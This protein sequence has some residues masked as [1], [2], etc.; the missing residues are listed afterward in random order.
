MALTVIGIRRF[1]FHWSLRIKL[2]I[3]RF[4]LARSFENL[5]RHDWLLWTLITRAGHAT[6]WRH[7]CICPLIDN[8][9]R[10]ITARVE[11]QLLYKKQIDSMLPWFCS[12]IDHRGRQNVVKTTVTHLPA[13]RVPLLC[14]YAIL[15]SSMIYYWTDA[16]QHGI[17]LLTTSRYTIGIIYEVPTVVASANKRRPLLRLHAPLR[18]KFSHTNAAQT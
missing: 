13:A 4:V 12:V 1:L 5:C 7:S 11:S 18:A 6:Q 14:F 9:H 8:R 15:T 2:N 17:Y 3:F 10:P 16:R